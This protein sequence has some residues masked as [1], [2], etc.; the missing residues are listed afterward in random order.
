M[1]VLLPSDYAMAAAALDAQAAQYK[2]WAEQ[3]KDA[4][5]QRGVENYLHNYRCYHECKQVAEKFRSK[6]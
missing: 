2:R 5:D 3:D 6:V 1:I 4:R